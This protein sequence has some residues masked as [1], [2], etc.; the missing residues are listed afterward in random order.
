[1]SPVRRGSGRGYGVRMLGQG[2]C[3]GIE[4]VPDDRAQLHPNAGGEP[5]EAAG[6]L[7]AA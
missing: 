3:P 1:M 6:R 2:D 5:R 4:R 7:G